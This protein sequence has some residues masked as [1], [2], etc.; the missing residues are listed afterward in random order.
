M[1]YLDWLLPAQW[2]LPGDK[3]LPWYVAT[4]GAIVSSS[5]SGCVFRWLVNR[6]IDRVVR[7]ASAGACRA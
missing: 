6:A 1:S 7:R 2:N 4:P 5:S 3:E